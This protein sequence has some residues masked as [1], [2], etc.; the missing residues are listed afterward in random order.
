MACGAADWCFASQDVFNAWVGHWRRKGGRYGH[1]RLT[2]K[3][4]NVAEEKDVE[5]PKAP[6]DLAVV[7]DN[8]FN[9]YFY[10][11]VNYVDE[12]ERNIAQHP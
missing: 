4:S 5:N 11:V 10:E 8:R 6:G 3:L 7:S 12:F 9:L 1:W 2:G